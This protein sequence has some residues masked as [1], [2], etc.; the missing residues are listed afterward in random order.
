MKGGCI[1]EGFW[2]LYLEEVYV[3]EYLKYLEK[4]AFGDFHFYYFV[5][6]TSDPSLKSP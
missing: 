3:G 4:Q 1:T 2:I 5:L 6:L